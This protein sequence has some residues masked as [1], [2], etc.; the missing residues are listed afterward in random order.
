[1]CLFLSNMFFLDLGDRI[2]LF[3]RWNLIVWYVFFCVLFYL[4]IFGWFLWVRLNKGVVIIVKLGIKIFV[5][6]G[7]IYKWLDFFFCIWF[8]CIFNF[9]N[10]IFV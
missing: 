7:W 9:F 4:I 3:V 10:I 8:C 1:M 2:G 5:I 6:F